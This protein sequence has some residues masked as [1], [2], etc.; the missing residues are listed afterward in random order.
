VAHEDA[1]T[2]RNLVLL[3]L[4]RAPF[5]VSGCTIV[6]LSAEYF[7]AKFNILR[8]AHVVVWSDDNPNTIAEYGD[9]EEGYLLV[10][11]G[12]SDTVQ[13]VSLD[14]RGAPYRHTF[15]STASKNPRYFRVICFS[16][17]SQI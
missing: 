6:G 15:R 2:W 13:W 14:G 3:D 16:N 5:P 8:E 1:V 4:G 11:F 17:G 9:L 10:S 12:T 7:Q